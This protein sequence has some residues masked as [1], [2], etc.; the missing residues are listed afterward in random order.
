MESYEWG[1]VIISVIMVIVAI[2]LAVTVILPTNDMIDQLKDRMEYHPIDYTETI[3]IESLKDGSVTTGSFILGSGSVNGYDVYI[4]YTKNEQGGYIRSHVD[5]SMSIIY[6]DENER[7]YLVKHFIET[8][9]L[10]KQFESAYS[11]HVPN[12]TVTKTF[13]VV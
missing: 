7:P 13:N 6:M 5:A 10:H 2:I 8:N 11:F 12:G 3:Y 9:R 4:Y 1:G